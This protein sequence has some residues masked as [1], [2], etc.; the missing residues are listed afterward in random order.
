MHRVAVIGQ[1]EANAV[2]LC[3]NLQSIIVAIN[4]GRRNLH[5]LAVNLLNGSLVPEPRPVLTKELLDLL[6]RRHENRPFRMFGG[7]T[8]LQSRMNTSRVANK[9]EVST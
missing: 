6:N 7:F 1:H 4:V 3:D 5:P 2:L 8:M 9:S